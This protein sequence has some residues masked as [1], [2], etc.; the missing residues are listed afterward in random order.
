MHLRLANGL[1][2]LVRLARCDVNWLRRAGRD[3]EE[4]ADQI[5]QQLADVQFEAEIYQLFRL[6]PEVLTSN[7]L[8]HRPP[9]YEPNSLDRSPPRY[10][11][12][13]AIFVFQKTPGVNN[14]WP[15]DTGKRVANSAPACGELA[16]NSVFSSHF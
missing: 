16:Y 14:V 10:L 9:T 11:F 3:T 8:Y 15:D 6:H 2:I 4:M 12:G 1:D 13:R 7:L 5:K